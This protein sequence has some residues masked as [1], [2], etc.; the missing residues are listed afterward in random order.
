MEGEIVSS[1]PNSLNAVVDT[2]LRTHRREEIWF[3]GRPLLR[4]NRAIGRAL[5]ASR[6]RKT[7][8]DS[9]SISHQ[10]I[11]DAKKIWF[12]GCPNLRHN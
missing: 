11:I 6:T 10:L 1:G 4:H 8:V 2:F 12:D 7:A 9:F 5:R 3:D